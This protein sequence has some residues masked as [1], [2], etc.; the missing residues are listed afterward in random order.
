MYDYAAV[1]YPLLH[2][3][4]VA[5]ALETIAHHRS[6]MMTTRPKAITMPSREPQEASSGRRKAGRANVKATRLPRSGA[7]AFSAIA[8]CVVGVKLL[9][10]AR[11]ELY[12]FGRWDEPC[13]PCKCEGGELMTCDTPNT[14]EV[15]VL[16]LNEREITAVAPHAFG[17]S[18]YFLD[19][20]RNRINALSARAFHSAKSLHG[21]DLSYN[22]IS[23]VEDA[24][25]RTLQSLALRGNHIEVLRS[26]MLAASH[27][28]ALFL[29]DN[30]MQRVEPGAFDRSP[31]LEFVWMG[32]NTVNC[33]VV[34]TGPCAR[35]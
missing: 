3:H 35:A 18:I 19:L 16:T 21:L 28:R 6:A 8:I 1:I 15:M 10:T 20:S 33:S 17:N 34:P 12:P 7:I 26:G 30:G 11:T 23:A 31:R 24:F 5:C 32:G 22:N 2:V 9:D 13:R 4:G 27:L 14:L 29:D 25:P